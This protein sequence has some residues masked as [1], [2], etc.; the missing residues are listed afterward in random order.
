M[1]LPMSLLGC[2]RACFGCSVVV[3]TDDGRH[4]ANACTHGS[5]YCS[6]CAPGDCDDCQREAAA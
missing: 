1:V 6:K 5:A 4:P 2:C 3:H